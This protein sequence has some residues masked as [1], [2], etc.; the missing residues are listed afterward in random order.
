M[1]LLFII[2]FPYLLKSTHTRTH[3]AHTL[4]LSLSSLTLISVY[5]I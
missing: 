5:N 1:S 4:S 3:H 2:F